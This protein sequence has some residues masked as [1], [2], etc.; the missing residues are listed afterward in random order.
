MTIRLYY[1]DSMLASFD[2]T[3][4][5][6]TDF[7]GKHVAVLD[8][9]AFYPTSG[10][11]PHDTGRL[12]AARVVDV[13]DREDGA[14]AHVVD[15]PLAAG[16]VVRGEID[17]P[18]RFDHMQQH[19][20]QHL[21]SAAFDRLHGARTVSFHLG[22]DASS[23]DLA[24][25]VTAGE[26]ASAE[27]LAS[28]VV[29]EDRPVEVRFVSEDE[30]AR[31]SLRKEPVRGGTLRLVGVSDFDL[32]ACGGTHVPRTGMVGAIAV[33]GA[34]RFRG[35]SRVTF[36][37]G[38]RA[39]DAYD[40]LRDVVAAASRLLSVSTREVPA[41]VERLQGDLR[42]QART[43]RRL[44]DERTRHHAAALRAAA[45][46][47]GGLRG[48]LSTEREGD[49]AALKALAQAV[50]AEPGVV[51]V[52]VGENQPRP[53]VIARSAGVPLDAAGWMA[54]ATAAFGGRGGGRP[55]L[56]QGGL[57]AEP[58]RILQWVRETMSSSITGS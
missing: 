36:V 29:W 5:T 33:A 26:I 16:E 55:E 38:R 46:T 23:I 10:G 44:S 37:C 1:T 14:I 47:I 13:V 20:G 35:G 43:V 18:R 11:Q 54:R 39:L 45:E 2:A 58:D 51:A 9:T 27:R 32:S 8:R 4:V 7:D 22:A 12:G 25:E 17:W 30:A 42:A 34:E 56:A 24:R 28:E 31:L 52:L 15:V 19:T 6:S 41:A 50:V 48:V 49:I 21:L 3:V 53:V 57:D 40:A